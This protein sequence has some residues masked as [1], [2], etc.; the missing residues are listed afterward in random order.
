MFRSHSVAYHDGN[1]CG[2]SQRTGTA[3]DQHRNTSCQR[4]SH[5]LSCK[6]PYQC[7]HHCNGNDHWYKH[8]GYFI[9]NLGN[10]C[11]GGSRITDHFDDLRK[12]SIFSYSCGFTLE[13][14]GLVDGSSRYQISPG[15]IHRN[16]FSCQCGFI[17]GTAAF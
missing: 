13:K 7:G 15:L 2:K 10:G 17:D 8:A 6:Q 5:C 16:T 1:R 12:C 4:I 9:C 14:A 11:L 3:D